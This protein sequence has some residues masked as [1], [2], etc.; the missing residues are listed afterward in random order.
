MEDGSIHRLWV[1]E[2]KDGKCKPIPTHCISQ[3]DVLRFLL[4]LA[5]LK[6][7]ATS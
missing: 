5:G 2:L 1:C 4:Y 3:R 7:T 6:P